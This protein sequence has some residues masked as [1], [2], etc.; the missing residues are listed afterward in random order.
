MMFSALTHKSWTDLTRRR[1]RSFFAIF[2]LAIAVASI[3][4]FA[5]P[6]LMDRAMQSEVRSSRLYDVQL[7]M[8]PVALCAR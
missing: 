6:T 7:T 8:S 2:T 1:A 5:V 4:I 3:G